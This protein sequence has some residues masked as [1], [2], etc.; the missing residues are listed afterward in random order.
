MHVTFK[1]EITK[2]AA[3][4]FPSKGEGKPAVLPAKVT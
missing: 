4:N 1:K 3:N 2:P